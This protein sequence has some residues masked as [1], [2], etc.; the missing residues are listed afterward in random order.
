MKKYCNLISIMAF[1]VLL[2]GSLAST[3]WAEE[4]VASPASV[5]KG[6]AKAYYMLDD[7]MADYLS[8]DARMNEDEVDMVELY[9]DKKEYEAY[10]QG[11]NVSYFKMQPLNMKAKVLSQDDESAKVEITATNIRSIN[12]LYRI[13]GFVFCLLDQHEVKEIV[14]VVKEDGE[15]KVGPGALDIPAPI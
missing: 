11:Y 8:E 4:G 1:L 7:K 3:A 13:V 10:Y 14:S 15:W 5:V 2:T 6:F 12:P 9:L